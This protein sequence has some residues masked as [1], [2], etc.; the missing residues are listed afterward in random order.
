MDNPRDAQP[1]FTFVRTRAPGRC[2]AASPCESVGDGLDWRTVEISIIPGGLARRTYI[3]ECLVATF[4]VTHMG[5]FARVCSRMDGQGAALDK[6]LVA[7]LDRAV[8]GSLI[9]VYSVV[10]T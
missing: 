6:T 9:G 3:G 10:P 4:V 1:E 7:V 2:K 8:V 5:F